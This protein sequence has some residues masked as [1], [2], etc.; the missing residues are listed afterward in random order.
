[1]SP[2]F[3]FGTLIGTKR[4][5]R[6]DMTEPFVEGGC[7]CG[8][9]RYRADGAPLRV[10]HCHCLDC[11][12]TS[13]APFETWATFKTDDVSFTKGTPKTYRSSAQ[14]ERRFCPECG[15]QLVWQSLKSKDEI[16]LTAGSM[17]APE[18]VTPAYHLFVRSRIAWI[19]TDDGLPEYE[20]W[21][22]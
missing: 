17:D 6:Q 3:D 22:D 2:G 14:A 7:H 11:R 1:M 9:I 16:D 19:H 15:T 12:R 18:R 4:G 8:A 5:L 13:G 10:N 21:R 20:A